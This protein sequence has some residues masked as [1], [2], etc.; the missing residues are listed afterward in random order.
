MCLIRDFSSQNWGSYITRSRT[1]DEYIRYFKQEGFTIKRQLSLQDQ[2]Q[3]FK[4][5]ITIIY[6]NKKV[7]KLDMLSKY[8]ILIQKYL[9]KLPSS[10]IAIRHYFL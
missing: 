2:K 7:Q 3:Y 4:N 10:T 1:L 5:L 6:I 8:K 9:V